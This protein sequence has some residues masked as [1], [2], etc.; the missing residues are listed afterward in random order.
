MVSRLSGRKRIICKQGMRRRTTRLNNYE[1]RDY[2]YRQR[3]QSESGARSN[4]EIRKKPDY[5]A[6]RDKCRKSEPPGGPYADD[7]HTAV[8]DAFLLTIRHRANRGRQRDRA[9]W[10]N[11][12]ISNTCL[13]T[14]FF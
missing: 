10:T 5:D 8:W 7:F 4:S 3:L 11:A 12:D 6:I 9:T 14:P 2:Y 1:D 13:Q